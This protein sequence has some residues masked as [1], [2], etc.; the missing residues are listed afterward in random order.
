MID[1][2]SHIL[3]GLDD[4]ARSPQESLSMARMA[5]ESGVTAMVATP[6][7]RDDRRREVY[8][9]WLLLREALEEAKIPLQLFL[10]MEIFATSAT[11]RMLREGAL[12]TVNNSRYPLLEF[13]F[14]AEG[15]RQTM[16]LG[17]VCQAGFR[18]VIAHPERYS[19]VQQDLRVVNEWHRMGCLLQLNRGSL[20]GRFGRSAQETAIRLVEHGF[21]CAIASDAHS[22]YRRTPWMKDVH[23]L[24]RDGLSP[25]H[26]RQLL[27][28]NPKKILQNEDIPSAVP[29][30]F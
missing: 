21:A 13:P 3:P 17:S 23:T 27:L 10:G 19:Y 9:S 2:H 4:G 16:I 20:L 11:A 25:A 14:H 6:H 12:F 15:S 5:V 22:P 1:L 18:P 28:E 24:L 8:D 30:W 7:C 26:A 29:D